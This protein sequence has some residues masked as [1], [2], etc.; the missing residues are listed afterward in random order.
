[1][2]SSL[3]RLAFFSV[4]SVTLVLVLNFGVCNPQ[5]TASEP[6][7]P[8]AP[9]PY[10]MAALAS[11][12]APWLAECLLSEIGKIKEQTRSEL[13]G[14]RCISDPDIR[15]RLD[16]IGPEVWDDPDCIYNMR[17]EWNDAGLLG[18]GFFESNSYPR[19]YYRYFMCYERR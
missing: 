19:Y 5:E 6:E 11:L 18:S 4:V 10:E 1:M 15:R 13:A 17:A 12:T 2:S 16:A 3:I 7:P 14:M 8:P 9:A